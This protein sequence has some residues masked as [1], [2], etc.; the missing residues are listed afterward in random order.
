MGTKNQKNNTAFQDLLLEPQTYATIVH[1]LPIGFS[2]VDRDGI[3][4]EFNAAAEKLTGYS[5]EDVVGRSH[6]EIIHGSKDP[7]SCPLFPCVFEEHTPSVGS[8]TVLKKKD[9]A[10]ITIQLIAFPLFDASRNLIGGAELFR[11][12]SEQ[13]RLERERRNLLSMFAHDMKN[14]VVS[15]GGFLTRLILEKAGPLTDKQKDYIGIIMQTVGG[16]R[17]LIS[18]FLDFSKFEGSEYKPVRTAYNLEEAIHRQAEMLKV[19]VEEKGTEIFFEYS[20]EDLPVTDADAGMI[21]RVIANLID[22][23][24]KYTDSGGTVTI[25]L[26]SRDSDILVEVLDTGIGIHA[27]DMA[28][29]FEA[30]Y[31]LNSDLKGSGLGLSIAKAIVEAHGGRIEVQSS[32]GKGSRFWFNLPKRQK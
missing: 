30:F 25:R 17:R 21:D 32:P 11:D 4:I 24:I 6:F 26:T 13:K 20:Q 31:R 15:A 7:R 10:P 5:S 8:E 18:D 29:V 3:I 23:A 19:G 27:Q 9:G 2:L 14:S 12:I 1:N 28:C 22:N 16:L